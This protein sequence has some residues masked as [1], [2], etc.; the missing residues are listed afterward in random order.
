MRRLNFG[1]IAAAA[2]LGISGAF[3]AAPRSVPATVN[4][5]N[6]NGSKDQSAP[7]TPSV[8]SPAIQT[9]K[10]R[11]HGFVTQSQIWVG[12][13]KRGNRRNRSRFNYNR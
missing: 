10:M 3:G 1:R 12:V 6:T 7:A 5:V 13:Q 11:G 9:I 4:T 8:A 2:I